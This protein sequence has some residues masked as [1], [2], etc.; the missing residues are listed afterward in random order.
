M[1]VFFVLAV[2]GAILLYSSGLWAPYHLD[3]AS[4]LDSAKT[5]SWSPT[6]FL[7]F[8]TFWLN[9]QVN[10]VFGP[11]FPWREPFYFRCSGSRWS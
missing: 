8:A 5:L 10:Q 9:A 11:I 2:A 3:D 6:R 1:R 7:G 4:V